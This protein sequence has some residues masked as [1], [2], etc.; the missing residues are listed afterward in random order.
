M[1][2]DY[3]G[4][5]R[6]TTGDKRDFPMTLGVQV[7][8]NLADSRRIIDAQITHVFPGW[9]K[10]E[11]C[12][13]NPSS[14]ELVN[15]LD[16]DFGS[17][18][19]DTADLVLHHAVGSFASPPWIVVGVAQYDVISELSCT[20]FKTLHHLRKEWIFNIRNDDSKRTAMSGRQMTSVNVGDVSHSFDGSD[21]DPTCTRADF[22]GFVE[23]VGNSRCRD[24]SRLSNI[25]NRY[26]HGPYSLGQ[27]C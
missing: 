12:N 26:T 25:T 8:D 20:G 10:I 18:D 19:S 3:V 17:H 1:E 9:S 15:Q 5:Q 27:S 7:L 13:R 6:R 2:P 4:F 11:K 14:R 22:S 24:A 16:A 21:D 23:N